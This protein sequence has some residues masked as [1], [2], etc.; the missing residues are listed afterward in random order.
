MGWSF[1]IA[2]VRGIDIKVH[3]TFFLIL[4]LGAFQWASSTPGDPLDGALFGVVL[5][6]LLFFCVTLHELGHS[7]A[8]QRFGIP[9]KEIVLMPLG[10]LA[11]IE[12]NPKKPLHELIIAAA[13]PVVNVVIAGLLLAIAVPTLGMSALNGQ[14]LLA[15]LQ[16]PSLT[17]MLLW[18]LAANIGLVLFN[19]I[20]AFP[21][22]GGRMLRAALAMGLGMPRATR[23]ASVVGQVV[24]VGLGLWA[25][26]T[27][28]IF[29]ILIAVFIFFGASQEQQ[30][31]ASQTV[32]ASVK[33]GD[34]YNKHALHLQVGD[35]LSKAVDYMMT[36][37]QHDFAVMQ[38]SNII[39][40]V[41]REDVLKTLAMSIGD[42][43][44]TEIMQ[45]NF[46]RVDAG[47]SLDEVRQALGENGARLAAVFD[48]TQYLGL[49]SA[50]DIREAF[51][52][53]TL[54]QRQRKAKVSQG[55]A[56]LA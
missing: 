24:A 52:V 35:R 53:S 21:L 12:K 6:L 14:A 11:L 34:A 36:S 41:A 2:Q 1:R 29:L 55:S 49:V 48:G 43:Y 26:A 37:Y 17:T 19:L 7:I 45:R 51:T 39:G 44:V 16:E 8:A 40:V 33:A 23:I 4:A 47:K 30:Q 42:R 5:M 31:T 18:L 50:E 32:L 10:G 38:G 46:L 25:V 22:D 13:G 15:A 28:Q 27:G 56:P 9:V 54:V 20:P 3:V